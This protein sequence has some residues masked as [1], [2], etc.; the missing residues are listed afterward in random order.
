M[1]YALVPGILSVWFG[2]ADL[3]APWVLAT[4]SFAS[5]AGP[6]ASTLTE[7][8]FEPACYTERDMF[9]MTPS[10][11]HGEVSGAFCSSCPRLACQPGSAPLATPL[12]AS[13]GLSWASLWL[14]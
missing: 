7:E 12:L 8:L 3:R 9:L 6:Q 4:F 14:S 13:L 10:V 2:C 11:A 5:L 1:Y